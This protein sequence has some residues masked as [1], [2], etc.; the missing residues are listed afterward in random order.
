VSV[1][2]V[3]AFLGL[4]INISLIS[5]PDTKDYWSSEWT[6]QIKFVG[7]VMSRDC[8]FPI[9]WMIRVGNDTAKESNPAI[10]RTKKVHGVIEHIEKQLQKYFVL[11]KNIAIAELTVGFKGKIIFKT[12]N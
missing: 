7:D 1:P 11:G 5:L 6:I 8:F 12:Y 2:E 10:K 3:K 4:I 9:F